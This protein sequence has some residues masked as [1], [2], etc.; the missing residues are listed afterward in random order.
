M[1]RLTALGERLA[2]QASERQVEAIAQRLRSLFGDG[3]IEVEEER[4]LVGGRRMNKRWLINPS[5]RF[6]GGGLK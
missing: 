5:L 1:E 3:A 2:G 6:L 4:V